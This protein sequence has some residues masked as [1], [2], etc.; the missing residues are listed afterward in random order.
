MMEELPLVVE[1][2]LHPPHATPQAGT[3]RSA[4]ARGIEEFNRGDLLNNTNPSNKPGRAKAAQSGSST[5]E[6]SRSESPF[7][8]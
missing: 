4:L 1:H 6:S 5:K 3:D 8:K 2:H 7:F